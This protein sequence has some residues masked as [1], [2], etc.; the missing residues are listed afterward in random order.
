MVVGTFVGLL[1]LLELLEF[2]ESGEF[3][4]VLVMFVV[5][6]VNGTGTTVGIVFGVSSIYLAVIF[7]NVNFPR[8]TER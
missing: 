1:E 7:G 6:L 8:D 4:V 2:P 3:I 5:G